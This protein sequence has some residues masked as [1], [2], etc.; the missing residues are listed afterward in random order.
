MKTKNNDNI[1]NQI[2]VTQTHGYL[3]VNYKRELFSE[4]GKNGHIDNH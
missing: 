2:F 4:I 1:L 3:D